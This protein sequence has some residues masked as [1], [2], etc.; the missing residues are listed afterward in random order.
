MT[1]PR[2]QIVDPS[3]PGFYHCVSRCVRRAFLCGE[4]SYTGKSF[5]HRKAWVEA[6]LLELARHF[7]VGVYAYAVMSNHLHVAL[8]VDPG[9]AAAWSPD[10]VA[11]R[12]VGV[13]PVC[14]DDGVD[15]AACRERARTIA[16]DPQRTAVCR[17]RLASLSWFMRCLCEPIARRANREDGCT[18][19][20]WEGRFKCQTLLDDQA[21]LACMAYVD[22]N[23]VRAGLCDSLEQSA[24]TSIPQRIAQCGAPV[25]D[26][27]PLPPLAGM[28]AST[29]P[30]VDAASYLALL[31][32]TGR[33]LRPGKRGRIT[34]PPPARLDS[35]RRR[36]PGALGA[37]RGR[38]RARLL[39]RGRRGGCAARQSPGDGPVLV[40]GAGRCEA[41]RAGGRRRGDSSF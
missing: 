36:R 28:A 17:E 5:E 16:G 40:E 3:A 7:A 34:G 32:W 29:G 13:F 22:L 38:H 6:R 9:A 10:E 35:D 21:V 41:G 8:H 11:R 31:D 1:S 33:Q 12:W 19:R 39:A 37:S 15:E 25:V 20:F 26:P 24:H 2:R 4:D 30:S 14:V 27:G 18:G 23:P